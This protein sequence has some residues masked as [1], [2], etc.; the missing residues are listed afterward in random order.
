MNFRKLKI[1]LDIIL[2]F[3]ILALYVNRFQTLLRIQAGS[4]AP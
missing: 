4:K 3:T 2:A 1:Y